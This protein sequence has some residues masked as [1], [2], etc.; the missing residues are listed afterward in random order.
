MSPLLD[1]YPRLEHF[2]VRGGEGFSL[3]TLHHDH[4]KS[5][6]VETGG[7]P[8]R[9]ALEVMGAQLPELDHL[10]LWIGTAHYGR[11]CTVEDFAPL[12]AGQL[13][14]KLR[15]LG[16][17]DADIADDVAGALAASLLLERIHVLDMSLGT[18]SD[19]GV[20]ALLA[21]PAL[22]HLQQIDIHHHY[23]TD[24]MQ[25]RLTEACQQAG[26]TLDASENQRHERY[27]DA[28]WHYVAVGE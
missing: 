5:L 11:T 9:V 3:G 22:L 4:L 28:E 2:R 20:E 17:R 23:C 26:V 7:L 6:T 14:P 18:L 16:L 13:F 24:E 27:Y 10:E 19:S 21:N 1:A 15:Y 12:F 8:R 25:A